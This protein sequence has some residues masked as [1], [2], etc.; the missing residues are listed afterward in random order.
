[1]YRIDKFTVTK[2]QHD[3]YN[4]VSFGT[5]P[6]RYD[7]RDGTIIG[8]DANDI[9][10]G[11]T[12]YP[13][14]SYAHYTYGALNSDLRLHGKPAVRNSDGSTEHWYRGVRIPSWF[15]MKLFKMAEPYL[16]EWNGKCKYTYFLDE[17]KEMDIDHFARTAHLV[18]KLNLPRKALFS[19]YAR[20]DGL[21]I[22][23]M[24]AATE[25]LKISSIK[26]APHYIQNWV[27]AA[28]GVL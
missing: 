14:G 13:D 10:H 25:F 4:L 5:I 26:E 8:V 27:A 18:K 6:H 22:S 17:I 3:I 7:L 23:E 16:R 9:P 1:M 2:E 12:I 11:L 19:L 28:R 20:Y 24:I 15:N 21:Q